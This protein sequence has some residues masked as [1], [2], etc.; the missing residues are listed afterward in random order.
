VVA[1]ISSVLEPT[2]VKECQTNYDLINPLVASNIDFK[3]PEPGEVVLK[4]CLIAKERNIEYTPTQDSQAQLFSYCQRKGIVPPIEIK[5][6]PQ[7]VPIPVPL[8]P[9]N[10]IPNP[11]MPPAGYGGQINY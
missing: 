2:F 1:Q 7:Y 3:N 5:A 10:L 4:L 6:M 8:Q 9:I 11:D